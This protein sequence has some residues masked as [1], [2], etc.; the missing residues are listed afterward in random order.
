[1]DDAIKFFTT[2]WAV[3]KDK[4]DKEDSRTFHFI[5]SKEIVDRDYEIV[6]LKGLNINNFKKN[7][8]ILLNHRSDGLPIG[9]ATN[10]WKK[11]NEL[12]VKIQFAAFEE[13]ELADTVRRLVEGG[14]L[15][16]LSIRFLPDYDK[17][18]YI[19]PTVQNRSKTRRIFHVSE[20]LEISV[21]TIPANAAAL[22]QAKS[23]MLEEKVINE[24]E[25]E[26]FIELYENVDDKEIKDEFNKFVNSCDNEKNETAKKS[27]DEQLVE[28]K[29]IL[30][31]LTKMVK[32]TINIK[33]EEQEE[34]EEETNYFEDLF[35]YQDDEV[36]T[37]S[38][39]DDISAAEKGMFHF[40]DENNTNQD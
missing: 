15:K 26:K 3:S 38:Q 40:L 39:S 6:N 8:V 14:Y 30:A 1:M 5:A 28:I 24:D 11:G 4:E 21:A 29:E 13:Y 7:P 12:H 10:I 2:D 9:K 17:I 16:S 22:L 34:Q 33:S 20:L 25:F 31:T 23:K 18:E 32:S 19:E 36:K 35:D 27:V 37:S